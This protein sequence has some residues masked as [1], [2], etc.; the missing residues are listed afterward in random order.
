MET[1]TVQIPENP[2]DYF[3]EFS[4]KEE[5]LKKRAEWR[6]IYKWLSNAIRHNKRIWKAKIK[7]NDKI[8][9]RMKKKG[10]YFYTTSLSSEDYLSGKAEYRERVKRATADIPKEI[11]WSY[12]TATQM[13]EIRQRMKIESSR[14]RELSTI[15][16]I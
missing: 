14:Q 2:S 15:A 16:K 10:W 5:Y 1:L 3:L 12:V 4:S 7:A 11:S 8:Y 9:R 13:L 6:E